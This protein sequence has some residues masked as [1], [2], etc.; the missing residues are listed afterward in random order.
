MAT[1]KASSEQPPPHVGTRLSFDGALCTVR[2]VGEVQGTK[3]TWLGVEWD[4]PSRGKHSG[5]HGGVKYFQCK[6][7]AP[8]AG[9]FV[10]PGRLRDR[11]RGFLEAVREKYGSSSDA[12]DAQILPDAMHKPIEISGKIVEEIGFDKIRKQLAA[13][14]EL[15][16]VILDDMRIQGVLAGNGDYGLREEELERIKKSC[17]KITELDLSR[18][19]IQ[20]WAEIADICEKLA[21]LR[22]LKLNGNRLSSLD[23]GKPLKGVSELSLDDTLLAWEEISAI[24][25]RFPDLCTLCLSSNQLSSIS[26]P[27]LSTITSLSL[28]SNRFCSLQ[29]LSHLTSLPNLSRLSVRGNKISKIR[30]ITDDSTSLVFSSTLTALDISLNQIDSWAFIDC[31]PEIFPGLVNLRASDNPLYDQPPAP[32]RITG[33]PE[34]RMTVDEAYMLTLARLSKLRMLN[35]SKIAPQDRVNGELYY[36]SLIRKELSA[37]PTSSETRIL[38]SH[39]RYSEL[40]EIYGTPEIKR[41]GSDDTVS[42]RSL[43]AGLVNFTFYIHNSCMPASVNYTSDKSASTKSI[44][45]FREEIPRTFDIYR[46]KA[47][48]ARH[49]ALPPLGFRLIW[50]TEEWDPVQDGTAEEDEWDSSD[51]SGGQPDVGKKQFIRREEEFVDSTRAVEHWLSQDTREVRVRVE[52]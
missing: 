37:S 30:G 18:N 51:E 11:P 32:A 3:G 42:P 28:E 40:C 52:L 2:Y 35:Y 10:R 47:I 26:S 43:A 13:L 16:V 41:I 39:P 8:T 31:L 34:K 19:L 4:D 23:G 44:V 48:V 21:D 7:S 46:V 22:K 12:V 24:S 38:S 33:L 5:E 17:P 29:S 1:L 27:I 14:Q 6:N 25:Y 9:S 36:L 15:K 20:D 45:E 50:E 49:F